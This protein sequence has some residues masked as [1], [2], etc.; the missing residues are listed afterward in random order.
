MPGPKHVRYLAR[1]GA[2][3]ALLFLQAGVFSPI[4]R[5]DPLNSG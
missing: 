1:I 5:A 2:T 3:L 4:G